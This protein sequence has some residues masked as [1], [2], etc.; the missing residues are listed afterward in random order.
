[1]IQHLDGCLVLL[2]TGWHWF[3]SHHARFGNIIFPTVGSTSCCVRVH[4]PCVVALHAARP[5]SP[6]SCS[7]VAPN[8]WPHAS[9]CNLFINHQKSNPLLEGWIEP[10][11]MD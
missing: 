6:K 5:L 7:A 1:M 9:W 10:S 4:C 11:L 8:G 3:E 2:P